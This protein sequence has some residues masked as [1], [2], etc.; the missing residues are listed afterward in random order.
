MKFHEYSLNLL[1]SFQFLRLS[2]IQEPFKFQILS[3]LS[4]SFFFYKLPLHP[5]VS[6]MQFTSPLWR[7]VVGKQTYHLAHTYKRSFVVRRI[8]SSWYIKLLIAT[9][10][11]IL[12]YCRGD[13]LRP[14]DWALHEKPSVAQLLK[15]FPTS[16]ET[17]R[18]IAV[19]TTALHWSLTSATSIQSKPPHPFSH[20]IFPPMSWFSY[21][22]LFLLTN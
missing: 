6:D 5:I 17:R 20:I 22:S 13:Q 2:L 11:L 10:L 21:W 19:F 12:T 16:Y 7:A 15:H 4:T 14:W 9:P 8:T 3:S 1:A 18:F